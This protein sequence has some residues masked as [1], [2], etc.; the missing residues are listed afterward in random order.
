MQPDPRRTWLPMRMEVETEIEHPETATCSP[1]VRRP[2]PPT[3]M[4]TFWNTP[5]EFRRGSLQAVN[6]LPI[7]T[8]ALRPTETSGSPKNL[9]LEC[10][11]RPCH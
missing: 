4:V 2:A 9:Q 8:D 10:H 1:I 3:L 11:E 6:F 5:S 7:S